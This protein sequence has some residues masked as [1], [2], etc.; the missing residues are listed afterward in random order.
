MRLWQIPFSTNVERVA[1][2]LA[3]KGLDAEPVVVEPSD[4]ERVRALSG[5]ELVPVLETGEGEV[6]ADSMRIVAHLEARFPQAPLWPADPARRAEAGILLDWFD[7]VW[8][9]PPNLIADAILAGDEPHQVWW[10]ELSGS[11]DRFVGLLHERPFL[12]GAEPS[13]VDIAAFPFLKYASLLDPADDEVFHRVLAQGLNLM[14][15][16]EQVRDWVQRVNQFPRSGV[17]T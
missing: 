7:R 2:A 4:R 14:E 17:P 13:V 15:R 10:D 8:K 12:L 9:R 6:I 5:Q 3:H 1:L 11:L 16:H